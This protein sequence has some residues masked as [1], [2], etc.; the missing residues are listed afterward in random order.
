MVCFE[1]LVHAHLFMILVYYRF[2]LLL[3]VVL[4]CNSEKKVDFIYVLLVSISLLPVVT[5]LKT[6]SA[7]KHAC[8]DVF[9]DIT[10]LAVRNFVT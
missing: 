9:F 3:L 5:G 7:G 4:I 6:K 1:K 10:I 2:C 8:I